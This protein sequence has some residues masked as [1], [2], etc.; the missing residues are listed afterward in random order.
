MRYLGERGFEDSGKRFLVSL[1]DQENW[2]LASADYSV[3]F[4][5]TI[6]TDLNQIRVAL[7]MPVEKLGS[8]LSTFNQTEFNVE[9]VID[10]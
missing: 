8:F 9:H 4:C 10:Y 6:L 5:Q 7:V 2:R 1:I 3:L